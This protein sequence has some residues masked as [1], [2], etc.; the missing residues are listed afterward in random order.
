VLCGG[1]VAVGFAHYTMK[2]YDERSVYE[3]YF[4]PYF[5][6]ARSD[7]HR[8]GYNQQQTRV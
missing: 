1:V 8:L 5:Y 2:S 6:R 7:P 4:R 3:T